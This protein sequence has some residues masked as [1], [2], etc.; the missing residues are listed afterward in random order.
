[1]ADLL[2]RTWSRCTPSF[3]PETLCT[4][5]GARPVDTLVVERNWPALPT[6]R[7]GPTRRY[8]PGRSVASWNSAP[9]PPTVATQAV[10]AGLE[11]APS[12]MGGP[13]CSHAVPRQSAIVL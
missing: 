2:D 1:M 4:P 7:H 8:D 5:S 10:V 9:F 13:S 6:L 3:L 12:A 11:P